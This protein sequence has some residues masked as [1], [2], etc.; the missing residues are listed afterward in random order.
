MAGLQ[1][2]HV[3]F[4]AGVARRESEPRRK[5]SRYLDTTGWN[6]FHPPKEQFEQSEQ[7]VDET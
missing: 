5:P 3:F 1:P 6:A 7:E 2:G 4:W